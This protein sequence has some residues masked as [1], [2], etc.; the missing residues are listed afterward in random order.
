MSPSSFF[1]SLAL[2]LLLALGT[3]S[4]SGQ[5]LPRAPTQSPDTVAPTSPLSSYT[6]SELWAL[7]YATLA[8]QDRL[9]IEDRL[10]IQLYSD[11]MGRQLEALMMQML[12]S[13]HTA[14]RANLAMIAA[15]Q[16]LNG[17]E[18]S[19]ASLKA[20]TDLA[21]K[22]ARGYRLEARIAE[23]VAILLA[24]GLGASLIF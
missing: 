13:K 21:I 6:P 22:K 24:L 3:I 1:P 5:G 20:D 15:T 11:Y 4:A 14:R 23:V 17:L 2:P 19:A 18:Q 10:S 7:F 12:D 9:L 8:E 16:A